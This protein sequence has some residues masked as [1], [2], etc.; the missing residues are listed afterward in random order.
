VVNLD[1]ALGEQFF[2]VAVGEAETQVPADGNDDDVGW[3][4][5][6]GEGRAGDGS[7]ARM[8]GSHAGESRCSHT[9]M[10]NATAPLG[11]EARLLVRRASVAKGGGRVTSKGAEACGL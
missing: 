1:A 4:A 9:V 6:A 2:D 3:E 8:A 10:A 11:D 5:E 7:G